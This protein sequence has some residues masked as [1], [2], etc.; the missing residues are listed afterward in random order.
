MKFFSLLQNQRRITEPTKGATVFQTGNV[1]WQSEIRSTAR[2]L[3][4]KIHTLSLTLVFFIF[5]MYFTSANWQRCRQRAGNRGMTMAAIVRQSVEEVTTVEHLHCDAA[6]EVSRTMAKSSAYAA[7]SFLLL[8]RMFRF[9]SRILGEFL[10]NLLFCEC[11]CVCE[12][13]FFF[14]FFSPFVLFFII[15]HIRNFRLGT[16]V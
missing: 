10:F 13:G 9:K 1:L 11:V 6:G 8:E 15:L 16:F 4:S 2:F 3:T 12:K 5:F 14:F 7:A